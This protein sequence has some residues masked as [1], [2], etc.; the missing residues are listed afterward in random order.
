MPVNLQRNAFLLLGAIVVLAL[1]AV[2]CAA[3]M[4]E[5][6]SD[7][8]ADQWLRENSPKYC[9]M[10]ELVGKR[11]GYEFGRNT[12]S[13]GGLAYIK[14]GKGHID[15][16]DALKGSH[17]VSVMAFEMTNLFQQNRH[18][19]ITMRV[20][21]GELRDE[22][23]FAMLRESVEYDG[24]RLHRE[25]LV[26]LERKVGELPPE[27]IS[28]CSSN[29]TTLSGYQLPYA[30]DYLKAQAASG[31]TEHY[32]KLFRRHVDEAKNIQNQR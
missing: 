31:H 3:T 8:A 11:W 28:W 32:R 4:P 9:S 25:I 16:N 24:L 21:R 18:E 19:E 17:R 23:Q 1:Q 29:A 7:A 20:R 30:Y 15:L 10:A 2:T 13:A 6:T 12:E 27:M 22:T 14:D 5:F 26:E